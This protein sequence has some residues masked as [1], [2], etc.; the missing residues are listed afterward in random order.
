MKR[1]LLYVH[2]PAISNSIT[3]LIP[4][5]DYQVISVV[6]CEHAFREAQSSKQADFLICEDV[7]CLVNEGE[8]LE[9]Y[10]K[11]FP[12]IPAIIVSSNPSIED[13][14][15]ATRIGAADYF[16][17]A[18]I[19][20]IL[21]IRLR[22]LADFKQRAR[23][24]SETDVL[25]I[26]SL[27][28]EPARM[29]VF[30]GDDELALSPTEYRILRLLAQSHKQAV[31]FEALAMHLQGTHVPH[32]EARRML[33]AHM[34]NLRTKLRDGGCG[35]PIINRRGFG[36]LLDMDFKPEEIADSESDD[37]PS[38][39]Y[40]VASLDLDGFIRQLTPE[41]TDI[42]GYSPAELTGK[43]IWELVKL[44]D[45]GEDQQ[46]ALTMVATTNPTFNQTLRFKRKTGGTV[47]LH[48][49]SSTLINENGA[50]DSFVFVARTV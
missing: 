6:D 39:A 11:E 18:M 30:C 31:S 32:K 41:V 44:I 13:A 34:S 7:V 3:N 46:F 23:M 43:S 35:E 10:L 45:I 20:S 33:S 8:R 21:L 12:A 42:L 48:V 36:Y 14:V 17:V 47:L 19:P 4:T 25:V 9:S 27:R 24:S 40:I 15:L 38:Q 49:Q 1:I 50:I 5:A 16:H 29:L 28:I 37:A 26:G 2:D 22:Q